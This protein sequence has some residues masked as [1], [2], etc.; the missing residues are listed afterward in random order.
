MELLREALVATEKAFGPD[1]RQTRSVR[2]ALARAL[3]V[4]DPAQARALFDQLGPED[5]EQ[6]VD[7]GPIERARGRVL[8]PDGK[9]AVG[10]RVYVSN[11]L[12][13]S[14]DGLPLPVPMGG[15]RPQIATTDGDGRF[16]LAGPES[17]IAMA[18]LGDLRSPVVEV[19]PGELTLR[20]GPGRAAEGTVEVVRGPP[21]PPD[22][23][24]PAKLAAKVTQPGMVLVGENHAV[25]YQA[26]AHTRPDGRWSAHHLPPMPLHAAVGLQTAL[27]DRMIFG[28]P[29]PRTGDPARVDVTFDLRGVVLDVIV[30]A[31]RAT[32]IP[33]AQIITFGGRL[34]PLPRTGK[35]VS[36]AMGDR[37]RWSVG[38]TGPVV[39]ANRT[40]AGA[41]HYQPNDIHARFASIPPGPATVCVIPLGGDYADE[42]YM[43]TLAGI[44]D[45]DATCRVFEVTAAP[46]IQAFVVETPP[47]RRMPTA[48]PKPPTPPGIPPPPPPPPR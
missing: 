14:D 46:A 6:K 47:M 32:A 23:E 17:S 20:L 7:D 33:S 9:P 26:L 37:P 34:T 22:A 21:P 1:H 48:L 31:D 8:L 19:V 2:R 10:A 18:A 24:Q 29:L 39:D 13:A 27:G 35:Q 15:T 16:D 45:I 4:R 44:Q 42:S 30:R 41:E 11:F 12:F 40:E 3:L 38:V 25:L 28:E 43:R 36:K 5:D